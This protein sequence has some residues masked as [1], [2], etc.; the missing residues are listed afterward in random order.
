MLTRIETAR[1]APTDSDDVASLLLGCHQRIRHFTTLA[2][3]LSRP[4][5]PPAQVAAAAAAVYRYYSQAL[6]LHEADENESVYPRL[7]DAIAAQAR[8]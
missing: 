6:P 1:R 7:R 3:N 8:R 5:V 4:D 2:L